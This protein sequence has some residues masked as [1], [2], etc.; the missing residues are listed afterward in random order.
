MVGSK[1][2]LFGGETTRKV[3]PSS[4]MSSTCTRVSVSLRV[5]RWRD[6]RFSGHQYSVLAMMAALQR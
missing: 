3:M 2:L 4:V 1:P 6:S 5:R